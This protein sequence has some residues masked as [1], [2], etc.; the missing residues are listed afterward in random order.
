MASRTNSMRQL[1]YQKLSILGTP[2]NWDHIV[3]SVGLFCF[4]GLNGKNNPLNKIIS[5]KHKIHLRTSM[6]L[7]NS[8][9]SRLFVKRWSH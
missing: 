8:R 1:L 5:N 4:T 3:K 2:G 9:V 7:F 6:C